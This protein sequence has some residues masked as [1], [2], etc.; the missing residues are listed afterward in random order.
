MDNRL[1][2]PADM[3]RQYYRDTI[4]LYLFFSQWGFCCRID[5]CLS[6]DTR[7]HFLSFYTDN[8][9]HI[10]ILCGQPILGIRSSPSGWQDFFGTIVEVDRIPRRAIIVI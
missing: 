2:Y 5:I 9:H 8:L 10:S 7:G 4:Y 3:F 1:D 6:T